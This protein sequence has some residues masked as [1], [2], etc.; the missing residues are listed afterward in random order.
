MRK[1]L[2]LLAAGM[3]AATVNAQ[4]TTTTAYKAGDNWYLGINGGVSTPL[5]GNIF[6]GSGFFK[7]VAPTV[8]LRIGKNLST[9][10]GMA[11]D[12]DVFLKSNQ[13]FA[14]MSFFNTGK[15]FIE[16]MNLDL[17]ATVNISNAFGGYCGK[18]RTFE[19]VALGGFGWSHVFNHLSKANG[20][21][22]RIAL[23]FALNLG[24]AKAWQVYVEP[25]LTYGL[26]RWMHGNDVAGVSSS[27]LGFKYDASHAL[28]S[29]KAGVNYKFGTSNHTHNFN[30][31]RLYDQQEIDALNARINEAR[32]ETDAAKAAAAAKDQRIAEL[33]KQL[34]DCESRP[35]QFI[36]ET[37]TTQE[38][39]LQPHVIFRQGKSTIDAAQYASI[40]MIAKYMRNH[41][42]SVVKVLGYASPEGNPELNQ[43]LSE[44]RANSVKDALVKRYKIA[45]DRITIEGLGATDK[46][47]SEND[48][49]RVAMFIDTTK[50][51]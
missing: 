4:E 25:S 15:T 29:V 51:P 1:T 5:M 7:G 37:T 34:A 31:S 44:A 13:Q 11:L 45:S 35:V 28:F 41:P 39:F 50:Q 20:I 18:P 47:S 46:L 10:F 2:L 27:D 21:N 36:E 38:V 12:G 42:E 9:V 43:R 30:V 3:M 6:Q 32:A 49:N 26:Q 33:E 16:Q 14:D 22:S 48:F 40:E 19:V 24:E 23:D 8:G 17:L